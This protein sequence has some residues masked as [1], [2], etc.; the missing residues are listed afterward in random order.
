MIITNL[1]NHVN[2]ML[3]MSSHKALPLFINGKDTGIDIDGG[4]K[5]KGSP[6]KGDI[7]VSGKKIVEV[8]SGLEIVKIGDIV[9]RNRNQHPYLPN[10]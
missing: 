6:K 1:D 5:V 2:E 9:I 4:A 8:K 10:S 7:I 3:G